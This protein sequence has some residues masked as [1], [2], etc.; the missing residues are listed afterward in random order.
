MEQGEGFDHGRKQEKIPSGG[1]RRACA[2]RGFRAFL[3][4]GFFGLVSPGRVDFVLIFFFFI[5][6][7]LSA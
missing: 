3:V 4:L 5:P 7:D 6:R 2:V 1:V